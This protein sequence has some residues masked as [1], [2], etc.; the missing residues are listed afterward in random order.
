MEEKDERIKVPFNDWRSIQKEE[1]RE[2]TKRR[3]EAEG[4][5]KGTKNFNQFYVEE[6]RKPWFNKINLDRSLV[7]MVNRLRTNHY[8]LNESL[9]RKEYTG[10]PRCE[11]GAERDKISTT[12]HYRTCC[13][14]RPGI[15]CIGNLR[16]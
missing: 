15:N 3:I 1:I 9:H 12:W 4:K 13:T 10:S 5:F 8:N 7:S 6:R 16:G 2:S 11:C 14:T